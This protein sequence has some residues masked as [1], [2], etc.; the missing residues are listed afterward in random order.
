MQF[1]IAQTQGEARTKL[2][3]LM[4]RAKGAQLFFPL[5]TI[6]GSLP[7]PGE[8]RFDVSRAEQPLGSASS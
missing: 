2:A 6:S 3:I 5:A 7:E 4:L 8:G 1:L